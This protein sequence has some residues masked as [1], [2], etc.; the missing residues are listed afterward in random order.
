MKTPLKSGNKIPLL[1]DFGMDLWSVLL[2]VT[3]CQSR[4]SIILR[5]QGS[6]TPRTVTAHARLSAGELK[7]I[8][9]R[10]GGDYT[11]THQKYLPQMLEQFER[12]QDL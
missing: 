8:I 11:H 7:G 9:I 3:A 4:K 2:R 6:N 12:R 10:Q 5:I 1:G